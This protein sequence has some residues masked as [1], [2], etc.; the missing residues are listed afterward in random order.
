MSLSIRKLRADGAAALRAASR[1]AWQLLCLYTGVSVGVNLLANLIGLLLSVRLDNMT[2]L[3]AVG[4]R[5][6]LMAVQTVLSMALAA[7]SPMWDGGYAASS[8]RLSRGE[9]PGLRGMLQGFTQWRKIL[10]Y[11]LIFVL[12]AVGIGYMVLM[13]VSFL[14]V[15]TPL[16][17]GLTLDVLY[18]VES[19][20]FTAQTLAPLLPMLLMGMAAI[21]AVVLFLF[22]RYRLF[23]FLL[24]DHSD[25]RSG[26]LMGL[27]AGI[28]K[29]FRVS[30]LRLDLSYWW[31][32]TLVFLASL[33]PNA[34]LFLGLA[35]V[36]TTPWLTAGLY[37]AGSLVMAAAYLLGRNRV[38][39]AWTAAYGEI[40][41]RHHVEPS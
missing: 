24:N 8:L 20:G 25:Q 14:Y 4:A 3:S 37:I 27:S 13:L 29:G 19:S 39:F 7:L 38:Q 6:T 11:F 34:D 15:S 32:Y 21:L 10:V 1:P 30:M 16:S 33:I 22:Y 2:G 28:T 17:A 26:F 9:N 41:A 40:L 5:S 18:A 31:Y 36:T 23:Y 12:Q 35:G